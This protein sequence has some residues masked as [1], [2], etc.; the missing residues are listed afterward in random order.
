MLAGTLGSADEM[1][2]GYPASLALALIFVG[3]ALPL[4]LELVQLH[5]L[6]ALGFL[7]AGNFPS[8]TDLDADFALNPL[9]VF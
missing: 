8:P 6:L 2:K 7:E 5:P 4:M 3:S 9:E 1:M